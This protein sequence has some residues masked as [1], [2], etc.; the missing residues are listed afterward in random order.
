MARPLKSSIHRKRL[1]AREREKQQTAATRTQL[2]PNHVATPSPVITALLK[3]S[4]EPDPVWLG[5]ARGGTS[6][7]F[8]SST[9]GP[10][11]DFIPP[12]NIGTQ[13]LP[14]P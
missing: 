5:S 2:Q 14:I 10:T 3:A 6:V 1:R 12:G 11:P 8:F 4:P 9:P 7:S 13:C